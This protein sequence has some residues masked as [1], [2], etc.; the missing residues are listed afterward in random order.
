MQW[1]SL[2]VTYV[3]V[4]HFSQKKIHL[5]TSYL[6]PAM[7]WSTTAI[8]TELQNSGASPRLVKHFGSQS[9]SAMA[10]GSWV[11]KGLGCALQL[12][13]TGCIWFQQ[14][15]TRWLLQRMRIHLPWHLLVYVGDNLVWPQIQGTTRKQE[16]ETCGSTQKASFWEWLW[17]SG[18]GW[19]QVFS[20]EGKKNW[21]AITSY[22]LLDFTTK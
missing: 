12:K 8:I 16:R 3:T 20:L 14:A 17:E 6:L 15:M 18:V 9:W 1:A 5:L 21:V 4:A 22:L 13:C 2:P 7:W 19:L 11:S 10:W